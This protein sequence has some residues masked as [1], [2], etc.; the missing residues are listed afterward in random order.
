M[1]LLVFGGGGLSRKDSGI[2]GSWTWGFSV[3]DVCPR[4]IS[5]FIT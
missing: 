2:E 5:S 4:W 1:A 3:G